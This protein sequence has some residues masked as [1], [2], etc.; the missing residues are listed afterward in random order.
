MK[1]Y[2]TFF[3]FFALTTMGAQERFVHK[4]E[5]QQ[6]PYAQ[7]I[8]SE[9]TSGKEYAVLLFRKSFELSSVP[10]TLPINISADNRYDLYINGTPVHRGP[11]FG[12]LERW[13]YDVLDISKYLKKGENTIAIKV[14]N[15]GQH[16]A[17]RQQSVH[18]ALIVQAQLPEYGEQLNTDDS[19]KVVQD[20]SY[21]PVLLSNEAIGGGYIAYPSDHVLAE[22][23]RPDWY[24]SRF[25]DGEWKN[26][27]SLG[28]GNEVGVNSWKTTQWN[29][30][31]RT[32]PI[33]PDSIEN[34]FQIR[35]IEGIDTKGIKDLHIPPSS[36]VT[37]LLDNQHLSMGYPLLLVSGGKGGNVQLRYQE[38]LFDTETEAK[39]DRNTIEGKKMKGIKD[40]FEL[41]GKD[42][43][44][45]TPLSLRTFRYV[46]LQ[47]TTGEDAI[48]LHDYYNRYSAFPFK[49]TGTFTTEH[50]N[51]KALLEA[52]WRTAQLC[53][54]EI[55]MDCPYYEQLQYIGDT[56]IQALISLYTTQNES[57][58]RN[59]IQQFNDSFSAVGL[60]QSRYPSRVKQIIPPFSLLYIL[61][62]HDYFMLREDPDFI[63]DNIH[64]VPLILTWF[65][66]YLNDSY[67]ITGIPYWNHT[68]GGAKGFVIGEPPYLNQRPNAQL[69]LLLAYG[70]DS[71]LEMAQ[72][73]S[74][75]VNTAHYKEISDRIKSNVLEHC[76]DPERGLL[77]ESPKK[78]VF[79]EHTNSLAI[80]TDVPGIAPSELAQN[81][82]T[83]KGILRA[84][85]YHKFYTFQAYAKANNGH[86]I[87]ESFQPWE[88]ALSLGMTTFPEH[89]TESR[90]DC[91]A[92][93]A[94]P[95][96]EL[97]ALV[98]GISPSTPGFK[99]IMIRPQDNNLKAYSAT[100]QHA[101]GTIRM[102]KK[103]PNRYRITLPKGVAGSFEKNGKTIAL[104]PGENNIRTDQN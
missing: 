95:L 29:L 60:T 44:R 32:I 93:S 80:L 62:L 14:W 53:A 73:L 33:F 72:S 96:Y 30:T 2:P 58:A 25:E 41:T 7:W 56:R 49:K 23:Q 12:S 17:Q 39:G 16:N 10:N 101:K 52:S 61:Q 51:I 94:H 31:P 6:A 82:Y 67:L 88:E 26:A 103:K 84:T 43:V 87:L 38:S 27:I 102:V 37:L 48:I 55:Y 65:E 77:A 89:G 81:M 42:S 3:I 90:S 24:R 36:K 19:W 76:F 100:V 46:E 5:H 9:V 91:H 59:A 99:T 21:R 98:A 34:N 11:S 40:L 57:L 70:I 8:S 63:A 64:I 28:Y 83:D 50:P 68:D 75:E 35:R 71:Y 74:L 104:R 47:I 97:P 85:T 86:L 4:R 54:H 69:A 15:F 78:E 92:W 66:R 18:T 1:W 20:T 45:Y 79:T 13:Y 22:G